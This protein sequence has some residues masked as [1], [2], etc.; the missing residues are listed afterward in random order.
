MMRS[1]MRLHNW[2]I[3]CC[4]FLPAYHHVRSNADVRKRQTFENAEVRKRRVVESQ[5]LNESTV[6]GEAFDNF[7]CD[8]SEWDEFVKQFELSKEAL[9]CAQPHQIE[10]FGIGDGQKDATCSVVWLWGTAETP[11]QNPAFCINRE[12]C[13]RLLNWVTKGCSV[14]F[15][16]VSTL[17]DATDALKNYDADSISHVSLGG[18]GSPTRVRFGQ[19]T[20]PNKGSRC[21]CPKHGCRFYTKTDASKQNDW[22]LEPGMKVDKDARLSLWSG[23]KRVGSKAVG[24][25][26]LAEVSSNSLPADQ[27]WA[28]KT[29]FLER[30]DCPGDSLTSVQNGAVSAVRSAYNESVD[31]LRLLS[32]KMQQ[33][34]TIVLDSCRTGECH[35]WRTM[36]DFISHHVA[37]GVRVI[38]P[39][40]VLS[41]TY[42]KDFAP[43]NIRMKPYGLEARDMPDLVVAS[44]A[45]T[46]PSWALGSTI[47]RRRHRLPNAHGNCA[48]GKHQVCV[49][50]DLISADD[51]QP[52]CPISNG[53]VSETQFLPEC[54]DGMHQ[55]TCTCVD[56]TEPQLR[57]APGI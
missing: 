26:Q 47:G 51:A 3:L 43:Y 2:I 6:A 12:V 22:V 13:H 35:D 37:K 23:S 27:Q 18:H 40:F 54:G 19:C 36:A 5:H 7:E 44:T 32:E 9:T 1:S 46:C 30:C 16:R 11:N 39:P 42:V 56:A 10:H 53:D 24:V 55:A 20:K 34:G 41:H 14:N 48:C 29:D 45:A 52:G 25:V 33:H 4:A 31:L 38:A 17:S 21:S 28:V 8:D 15:H 49:R 50:T 57:Q